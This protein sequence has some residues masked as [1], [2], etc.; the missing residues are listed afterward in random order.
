M[1]LF[2]KIQKVEKLSPRLRNLYLHKIVRDIGFSLVGMFGPIFLYVISGS[3]EFVLIFFGLV[4]FLSFLFLPLLA[5]VLKYYSMHFLM[6][7][8]N[9]FYI[10]YFVC[11]YFLAQQGSIVWALVWVIIF[12]RLVVA[13]TYWVPYHIDLAR[14][15]NKHHRDR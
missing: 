11:L 6:A 10:F 9:L 12:L 2:S 13:T 1:S 7:V 4:Y 15:V 14:F 8:G 3:F 5:K